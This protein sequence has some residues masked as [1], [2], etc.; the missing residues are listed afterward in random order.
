MAEHFAVFESLMPD[1]SLNVTRV[2]DFL[3][4][5]SAAAA[6]GKMVVIATWPGPLTTPFT[7]PL[8]LP[9]WP[10]GDQPL[11]NSGWRAA[12]LAK[13]AFALAGYLTVA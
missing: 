11:N 12:L 9:S 10:G 4:H 13:R 5:V 8:G 6:A 2:V 7:G 1:G 3:G